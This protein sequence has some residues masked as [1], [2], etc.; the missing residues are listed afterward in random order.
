MALIY[1]VVGAVS[2]LGVSAK[3]SISVAKGAMARPNF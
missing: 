2:A 1:A 3:E